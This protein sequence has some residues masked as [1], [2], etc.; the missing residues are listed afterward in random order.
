MRRALAVILLMCAGA[1][2]A[3]MYKWKD[4]NGVTHYT[5][6]PP[7]AAAA[8][9]Q[10]DIKSFAAAPGAA[11]LPAEL[12][13]VAR[14]HPVTLYTTGQ[15]DACNQ[16]RTMLQA[17]GIP[18]NEKTVNSNE[19]QLA[20]KRAGSPGQLPLLLVGRT[21]QIGFDQVTWD[22][23]MTDAGYPLQRILP[24]TYQYPPPA[25]AAPARQ[26]SEQERA[27]AAAKAAA[28]QAAPPQRLPPVNAPPDFQF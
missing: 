2:S 4:A 11:G 18:Y 19:D 15:C 6:T 8:S 9:K 28:E 1:A 3:Q 22:G 23:L 14:R 16:A 27:Q 17:R 24:S 10:V 12:A 26:P 13:E 21:K 5:D 7:P 20:L 25:A